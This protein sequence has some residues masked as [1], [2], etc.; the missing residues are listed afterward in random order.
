MAKIL[1]RSQARYD[2]DLLAWAERQAAHLRA[3]QLD[4]LDV[5]HLIEELEAMA[6]K[7]RREL[8]NRMRVLLAH[9]LK[10]QAQPKR[11]SR[12]WAATIAEQRDQ[13]AALLEENPSLWQDLP[14]VARSVY[15]RA[16]RLAAI[17]TGLPRQN[18]PPELPYAAEQILGDDLADAGA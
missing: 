8:K 16:V 1:E 3:G 4:R 7:L 2:T 5:E 9:L 11:R 13:I 15:P 17:E 12:S 18:F 14:E 10:W 6:G